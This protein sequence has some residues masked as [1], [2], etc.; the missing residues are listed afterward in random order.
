MSNMPI[1]YWILHQKK[2]YTAYA[3][4]QLVD[5]AMQ[6]SRPLELQEWD[7]VAFREPDSAEAAESPCAIGKILH[8]ASGCCTVEILQ[9]NGGGDI[10]TSTGQEA[11][12]SFERICTLVEYRYE[13]R[14]LDRSVNP[15]MEHAHDVFFLDLPLGLEVKFGSKGSTT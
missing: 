5:Y 13:Q 14:Q 1:S 4:I 11:S 10:W 9:S 12:I 7:I 2:N 6:S 3:G 15:H 8:V